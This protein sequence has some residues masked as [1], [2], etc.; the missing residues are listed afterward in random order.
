MNWEV[1]RDSDEELTGWPAYLRRMADAFP[2]YC[3]TIDD[4]LDWGAATIMAYSDSTGKTTIGP[5]DM[6]TY[7]PL[8]GSNV[9]NPED[10]L[11]H[12]RLGDSIL[13]T[14]MLYGDGYWFQIMA[15][16]DKSL[17]PEGD[18]NVSRTKGGS[19]K[20]IRVATSTLE[21]CGIAVRP[22][23]ISEYFTS[24]KQSETNPKHLVHGYRFLDPEDCT[25]TSWH[26]WMEVN[27][28]DPS[29]ILAT[30]HMTGSVSV[31][32]APFTMTGTGDDAHP[33]GHTP[34]DLF[35]CLILIWMPAHGL[36]QD[37][38]LRSNESHADRQVSAFRSMVFPYFQ[39]QVPQFGEGDHFQL[40][41]P[42][43]ATRAVSGLQEKWNTWC[44]AYEKMFRIVFGQWTPADAMITVSI[45]GGLTVALM[46]ATIAHS[47]M[48][49]AFPIMVMRPTGTKLI[50]IHD[51]VI[52][53]KKKQ[54][55]ASS[56]FH[57]VGCSSGA[58]ESAHCSSGA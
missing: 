19:K 35:K 18:P 27:P 45:H 51:G 30:G 13:R 50:T 54:T 4:C 5:N 7:V 32:F 52:T 37:G 36:P 25:S 23:R 8:A 6:W 16:V 58:W 11:L 33:G 12:V 20:Q 39:K 17:V 24:Q 41:A 22:H 44:K 38:L 9:T 55:T 14:I 29:R 46:G 53:F 3:V 34:V 21:I 2:D 31:E 47:A 40:P 49:P 48:P 15:R 43:K 42:A 26:P 28:I 10:T 57:G 56:K 1:S